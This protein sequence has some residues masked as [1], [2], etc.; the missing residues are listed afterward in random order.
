MKVVKELVELSLLLFS[1]HPRTVDSLLRPQDNRCKEHNL[2]QYDEK[3]CA[4]K[5]VDFEPNYRY[6]VARWL[7]SLNL[8][9]NGAVS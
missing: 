4:R 2:D 1:V 3:D 8:R 5:P 9:C 6:G 7:S